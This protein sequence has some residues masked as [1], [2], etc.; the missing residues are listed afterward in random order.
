MYWQSVVD[1]HALLTVTW[2]VLCLTLAGCSLTQI[3]PI[4]MA[5]V[6]QT[7]SYRQTFS[8]LASSVSERDRN[9]DGADITQFQNQ[10]IDKVFSRLLGPDNWQT[11]KDL[12]G[13]GALREELIREEIFVQGLT[14]FTIYLDPLDHQSFVAEGM[15]RYFLIRE[16]TKEILLSGDFQIL[17]DRHFIDELDRGG[18]VVNVRLF[19]SRIP[20]QPTYIHEAPLKYKIFIDTRMKQDG[21][22]AIDYTKRHQVY[23]AQDRDGDLSGADMI[24]TFVMSQTGQAIK[25]IDFRGINFLRSDYEKKLRENRSR[26]LG[27]N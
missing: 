6:S 18:L 24:G 8:F 22:Y 13:L 17:G 20:R 4:Q 14:N 5:R 3:V 10:R 19:T 9:Q 23:L 16:K 11:L 7:E 15:G 27:V 26:G 12:Y 25:L 1:A 2:H 21:I